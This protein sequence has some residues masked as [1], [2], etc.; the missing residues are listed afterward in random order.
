MRRCIL[1]S[2]LC[3][4]ISTGLGA[5][6]FLARDR[7]GEPAGT[8][9]AAPPQVRS[10]SL[11]RDGE[12]VCLPLEEYLVGAVAGEMP[13]A[14]HPQALRAQAVACR[15]FAVRRSGEPSPAHPHAQVCAD[16]GCCQ[17]WLSESER[18]QRWGDSF[19][20]YERA[21]RAAAEDTAGVI[22]TWRGEPILACFHASSPDRTESSGAVW[23]TA[24]PYLVSVDTPET[25]G[26]VPDFVTA[27]SLS[28]EELRRGV[29]ELDPRASFDAPP[30]SWIGERVLDTG[31]RV[32]AIRIGGAALP[33]AEVR[34][35]FSL[36]S[37]CFS[38][39]WTGE[40]FLFT[41]RGSGHGVGMSQYGAQVMAAQ[42]A[43]WREI[44][45]HYYPGS[46]PE[47][48]SS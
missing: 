33:G 21:V 4:L 2:F 9:P 1:L 32:A 8:T 20:E 31:G 42:G 23:G 7:T 48:L 27:V 37:A 45:A 46:S 28:A 24:L 43:G 36:R 18:R 22:L 6:A 11:L 26:D 3:V 38:L 12:L 19:D 16:P 13:A 47:A 5:A 15:T 39:E 29:S 25:A 34:K 40:D 14:F 17:A 41:V 30:E 10:I 35:A 44:L